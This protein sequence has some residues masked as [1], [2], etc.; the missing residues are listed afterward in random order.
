M[1]FR[2]GAAFMLMLFL[3]CAGLVI[4]A[5]KGWSGERA[6]VEQL[7]GSLESMIGT[8]VESAY[9]LLTV[10]QRH[11]PKEDARL[12]AVASDRDILEGNA[13]LPE[14]AAANT[15]LTQDGQA[16]LDALAAL[17]SVQQDDRDRMYVE[18]YLPQMLEESEEKTTG[19]QYNLAAAQFNTNLRRSFSGRLALALGVK[20]AQEF[21]A[22]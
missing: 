6:Q 19:A 13:A 18:S 2:S 7:Q 10:A 12:A 20:A 16:L 21:S 14:K 5:Y 9:N 22:E 11:L 1:K 3:V 17:S 4:G 15:R 8:R